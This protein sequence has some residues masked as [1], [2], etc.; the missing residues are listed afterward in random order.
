[1]KYIYSLLTLMFLLTACNTESKKPTRDPAYNYVEIEE[2]TIPIPKKFKELESGK[3]KLY[4]FVDDSDI[5]NYKSIDISINKEDD[6]IDSKN[7][8]MQNKSIQIESD[9]Y[10]NHFKIIKWSVVDSIYDSEYYNLFGL[11]TNINLTSSNKS[12]LNYLLDYCNK[13]WKLNKGENNASTSK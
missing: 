8:I 5:K 9:F 13:T 10:R 6:Y 3:T 4:R 1:M 11:K 7:F 12:E 2:C